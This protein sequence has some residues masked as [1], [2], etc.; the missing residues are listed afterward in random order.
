VKIDIL[1]LLSAGSTYNKGETKH[2]LL[3]QIPHA[4][5]N[6]IPCNHW[7][8]TEKPLEVQTSIETWLKRFEG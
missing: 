5:V 7:P 2:S 6:E 8:L 1:I 4:T 3:E